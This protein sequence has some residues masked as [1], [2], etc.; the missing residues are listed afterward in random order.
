MSN[1]GFLPPEYATPPMAKN[2]EYASLEW[3]WDSSGFRLN[4]PGN[5][6]KSSAGS[7]NELVSLMN[8]LGREGWEIATC[9]SGGNW[10]FWTFKRER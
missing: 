10:L 8:E 6:E 7:Y 4:L 3:L 9:A 2:F 5:N 1:P